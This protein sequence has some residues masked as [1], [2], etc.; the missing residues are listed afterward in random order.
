[1]RRRSIKTFLMLSE[2]QLLLLVTSWQTLLCPQANYQEGGW[3]RIEFLS[4]NH[5]LIPTFPLSSFYFCHAPLLPHGHSNIRRI[6]NVRNA[7][8]FL[9]A[10]CFCIS[11][12]NI[13]TKVE[14]TSVGVAR[15]SRVSLECINTKKNAL[16]VLKNAMTSWPHLPNVEDPIQ[17]LIGKQAN[18]R[19]RRP[20]T[21]FIKANV[22]S[23]HNVAWRFP[24][25][26]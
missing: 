4:P 17:N 21:Q 25:R 11:T 10:P 2:H 9:T 23:A 7:Q 26:I 5:S 24:P 12:W 19:W 16:W 14:L 8:N 1:M 22:E 18:K 15:S 3:G 13:I 6:S 20:R